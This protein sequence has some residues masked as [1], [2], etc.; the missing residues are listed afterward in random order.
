VPARFAH[1]PILSLLPEDDRES[2]H[3][4]RAALDCDTIPGSR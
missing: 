3:T 1:E 2:T 4:P